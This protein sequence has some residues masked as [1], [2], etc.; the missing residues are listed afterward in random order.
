MPTTYPRVFTLDR[1][2]RKG[3]FVTPMGHNVRFV[4]ADA[5][6]LYSNLTR[7]CQLASKRFIV[8]TTR[9]RY[10][11]MD[12]AIAAILKATKE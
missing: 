12:A 4:Q 10:A 6:V 2:A 9:R 7:T 5:D 8:R 11:S 1:G 3:E